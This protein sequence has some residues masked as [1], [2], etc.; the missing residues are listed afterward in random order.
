M[1]LNEN[2]SVRGIFIPDTCAQEYKSLKKDLV[3]SA[4]IFLKDTSC[5]H[6]LFVR[7]TPK[8]DVIIFRADAT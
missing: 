6:F 2:V 5:F 7:L 1:L 3:L 4:D 8:G